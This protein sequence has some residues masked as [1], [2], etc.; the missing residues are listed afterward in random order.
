MLAE[1]LVRI[2]MDK[3]NRNMKGYEESVN[4]R[5]INYYLRQLLEKN[6]KVCKSVLSEKGGWKVVAFVGATGVG[7]TTTVAKLAA[8]TQLKAN[9]KVGLITIDTYRIAAIEQLRKYADIM[10]LPLEVAVTRE[11][12]VKA[13][14]RFENMDMVLI[15]TAGRNPL[16]KGSISSLKEMFNG[17][18]IEVHLTLSATTDDRTN[19]RIAANFQEL[20][21]DH[22]L[23]TKLDETLNYG[24]IFNTYLEAKKKLSFLTTGQKVPEDIEIASAA[25]IATL[26]LDHASGLDDIKGKSKAA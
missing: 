14:K 22:L 26:L 24:T 1:E 17:L 2:T 15:D 13:L 16:D 7:K 10:G 25:K 3:I 12:L 6:I 19:R 4:D 18:P 9:K 11:G 20:G 23:F 21:Y 8:I 5:T